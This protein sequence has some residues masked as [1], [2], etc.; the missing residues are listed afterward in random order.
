M[1]FIR[2][3]VLAGVLSTC[4]G[5]SECSD[6]SG[7][8]STGNSFQDT[9]TEEGSDRDEQPGTPMPEPGSAALFGI[10]ALIAIAVTRQM[11]RREKG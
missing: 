4:I 1:R 6:S 10:G 3:L 9:T 8:S 7:S 11:G 2:V 5:A